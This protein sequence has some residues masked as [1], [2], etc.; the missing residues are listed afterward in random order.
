MN[1]N[2]KSDR[3]GH[4]KISSS[5]TLTRVRVEKQ[6][7]VPVLYWTQ[8]DGSII[9]SR[10]IIRSSYWPVAWTSFEILCIRERG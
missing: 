5:I 6:S 7:T 1:A 2:G 8:E 10:A 3:L 4:A 9:V